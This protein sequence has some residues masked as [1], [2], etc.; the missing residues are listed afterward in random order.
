[1]Q[2][3]LHTTQYCSVF[4]CSSAIVRQSLAAQQLQSQPNLEKPTGTSFD[5][6]SVSPKIQI[7]FDGYFRSFGCD[8]PSRSP[9][10]GK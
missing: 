7:S 5:I 1:M 6:P 9:P 10:S 3:C 8:F 4:S 2:Q